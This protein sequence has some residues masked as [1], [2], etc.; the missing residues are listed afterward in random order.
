MRLY[1]KLI[2]EE[3]SVY[4]RHTHQYLFSAKL[5]EAKKRIVALL[6]MDVEEFYT[7]LIKKLN[8]RIPSQGKA[9]EKGI[10]KDER[11]DWLAGAW[12]TTTK[13]V[14][15][16]LGLSQSVLEDEPIPY[17][18]TERLQRVEVNWSV[19]SKKH[20][21]SKPEKVTTP[22]KSAKKEEEKE[23]EEREEKDLK[24]LLAEK[25][26]KLKKKQ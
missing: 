4:H 2:N 25:L 20:E 18:L 7:H 16:A 10:V 15:K 9:Y 8:I 11:E 1:F 3:V 26:A 12:M 24:S 19:S 6:R 14:V 21:E 23:K 5:N 13:I 17:T 22:K